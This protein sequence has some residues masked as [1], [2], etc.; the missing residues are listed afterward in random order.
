V[1]CVS[2]KVV[3][4]W[5]QHVWGLGFITQKLHKKIVRVL[6]VFRLRLRVRDSVGGPVFVV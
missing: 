5:K 3:I 1:C 6:F 4:F 2:E